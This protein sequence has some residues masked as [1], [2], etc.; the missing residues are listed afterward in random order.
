MLPHDCRH[1]RG[2]FTD[3]YLGTTAEYPR[4]LEL[5]D[6]GATMERI[7][8]NLAAHGPSHFRVRLALL[9]RYTVYEGAVPRCC[10]DQ[11]GRFT[12]HSPPASSSN[13]EEE[14]ENGTQQLTL[15]IRERPHQRLS[16]SAFDG[17]GRLIIEAEL[18]NTDYYPEGVRTELHWV[19]DGGVLNV[20][21]WV[22]LDRILLL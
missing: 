10:K 2:R 21:V 8:S 7:V 11:P 9:N 12:Y 4:P 20:D 16:V 22:P 6:G 13:E 19:L 17:D 1:F 3:L 15:E 18:D 5:N 14:E